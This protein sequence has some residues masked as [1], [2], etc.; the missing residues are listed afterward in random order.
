[1]DWVLLTELS[2]AEG[3]DTARGV[4]HTPDVGKHPP[5]KVSQ[6]KAVYFCILVVE[7]DL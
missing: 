2:S 4:L 7:P 5:D 1:M 3:N 6:S